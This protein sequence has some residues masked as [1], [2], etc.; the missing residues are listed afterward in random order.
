MNKKKNIEGFA[1]LNSWPDCR[2]CNDVKSK[3]GAG[4]NI[5]KS[6]EEECTKYL[7]ERS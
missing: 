7:S 2:N 3:Y 6:L 1:G 5:A 4:F